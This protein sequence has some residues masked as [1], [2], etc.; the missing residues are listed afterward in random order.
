VGRPGVAL[1]RVVQTNPALLRWQN[2]GIVI[3]ACPL[4]E[5]L[6]GSEPAPIVLARPTWFGAIWHNALS[7]LGLRRSPLGGFGGT[8]PV[9]F[10]G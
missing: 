6:E 8:L 10:G 1:V 5:N 9:P 7:V 2:A 3:L 4:D